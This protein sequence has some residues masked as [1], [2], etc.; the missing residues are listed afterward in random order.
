L[1]PSFAVTRHE[2]QDCRP[3]QPNGRFSVFAKNPR[4]KRKKTKYP[5][6]PFFHHPS[7]FPKPLTFQTQ[8]AFGRSG[9]K[10]CPVHFVLISAL[11]IWF[12]SS[13]MMSIS[14]S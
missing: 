12:L 4:A 14:N 5:K 1:E 2:E 10:S 9:P 13:F 8:A 6:K 11:V 3:D 7:A